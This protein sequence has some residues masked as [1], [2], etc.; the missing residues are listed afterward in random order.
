MLTNITFFERTFEAESTNYYN[1]TYIQNKRPETLCIM[2]LYQLSSLVT[3]SY[4]IF[5]S[6]PPCHFDAL[7]SEGEWLT[8]NTL[9]F[10]GLGFIA[11]EA[12]KLILEDAFNVPFLIGAYSSATA[13]GEV[14]QYAHDS[15]RLI[16]DYLY[17]Y[18]IE[19]IENNL[20]H[21]I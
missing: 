9:A 16:F 18:D 4:L 2:I 6:T 20:F 1:L 13:L 10:A 11:F 12:L 7:T 8:V 3:L 17:S 5:T 19:T 15:N 21:L 14:V